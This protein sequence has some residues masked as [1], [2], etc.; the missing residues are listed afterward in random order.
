MTR[1]IKTTLVT[2]VAAL[3]LAAVVAPLASA[4]VPVGD[5][6]LSEAVT[7]GPIGPEPLDDAGVVD[8][9]DEPHNFGPAP[10]PAGY[11]SAL[12]DVSDGKLFIG[13]GLLMEPG[14]YGKGYR[15]EYRIYGDDPHWDDLLKGPVYAQPLL[16]GPYSDADM[17]YFNERFDITAGRLLDED[18]SIFD[19]RDE[20]Y[21][22]VRLLDASGKTVWSVETNRVLGYF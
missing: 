21:A 5:A 6:V 7:Q 14:A 3:A 1:K 2:L 9:G 22:R 11:Y 19:D 13:A 15:F 12:V 20:I 10:Y 8:R 4:R 17:L 18:D 16:Q